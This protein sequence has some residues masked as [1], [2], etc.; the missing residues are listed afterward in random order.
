MLLEGRVYG[1]LN[2]VQCSRYGVFLFG[3]REYD[4]AHLGTL[5]GDFGAPG[6]EVYQRAVHPRGSNCQC[7]Q[8]GSLKYL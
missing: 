3:L 5:M 4:T 1:Y 2:P 7:D 8:S 6:N